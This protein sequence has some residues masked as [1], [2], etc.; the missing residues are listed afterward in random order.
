MHF[1]PAP[2][3][4]K[5]SGM[6][7]DDNRQHLLGT[8]KLIAAVREEIP[9]G[10][11]TEFL[12]SKPIGYINCG[13]DGRMLVLTVASGRRKP[14]GS[15]ATSAE[16]EALFRSMTSYG[17][18]YTIDGNEITHRVDVSWNESWTGTEQKRL[19]R[20]EDNRVYLSTPPSL[21]PITGTTSV[22]TMTWEKLG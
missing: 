2:Q 6:S 3:R 16:V 17:G 4:A 8:W 15:K 9:S 19:A 13:A 5:A 20:F 10:I 22:R 14:A 18:T 12:G 11:K 21:D 1:A 7:D